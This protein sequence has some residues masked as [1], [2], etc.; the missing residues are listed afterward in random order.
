MRCH[1]YFQAQCGFVAGS[2]GLAAASSFASIVEIGGDVV[3]REPPPS[4]LLD[5]W[6]S[7]T[8][9]R[10]WFEREVV[11]PQDITLGHVNPGFVN[12]QSQLVNG[13]VHAGTRVRSYMVRT[14]PVGDGPVI[15]SGYVIFDVPILGVYIGS[16][17]GPTDPI[18]GRPGVIYN[19]NSFRGLELDANN[20]EQDAFEISADR[21]RI[22]FVHQVGRWT[23]DIRI[24][25]AIPGPG[26]ICMMAIGAGFLCSRRKR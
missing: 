17:L 15:L 20:P 5:Q 9:I 23:D 14:D 11:L 16:Q 2:I 7:D 8:E 18:L 19:G 3:L 10:G 26:P 12:D 25:T 21:L 6:E 22:D 4:I 24:V 13:I 1:R